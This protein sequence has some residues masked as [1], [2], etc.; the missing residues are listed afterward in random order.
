MKRQLAIIAG[1]D[2]GRCF[3]LEDGQTLFIGRGEASDT[4]IDD[5]RMSRVHCRVEVDGGSTII[6]DAE[7][8]GGTFVH[9]QRVTRKELLPG[10]V[11]RI[12]DTQLRYDLEGDRE[13]TTLLGSRSPIAT[14]EES[15]NVT[16]LQDLVGES[17]A[18]YQL[19][20][21]LHKGNTG[22]VFLAQDTKKARTAAVKVL[23]P[24]FT[25]NEEEK[26]RFVRAVQTMVNIH[27]N[28]LVELYHAGKKG[29]F[30][31]AA[32]EYI[33]GPSIL[34]VIDLIGIQ[35]M[36]DWREAFRVAVHVSRALNCAYEN[37]IIHR[38]VTPQNL[39]QRK[40]DK[41]VK[42]CDLMLA[43]AL[44]GTMAKQVTQPGQ[45][46]GDVAYMSPERTREGA[47]VDHRSDIYG[48]GAT[49]YALL[50]GHPPFESDS[51]PELVRMVRETEPVKPKEKQLSIDERFQNVVMRMLAKNPDDRYQNP[52]TLLRELEQTG[53]YAGL[54]GDYDYWT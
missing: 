41:V 28:N 13:A 2:K 53:K 14:P 26:D 12:G 7:S 34:E 20:K 5:A 9:D 15:I 48:L 11:I 10:S 52:A 45:L 42:L 25:K 35:G 50:V 33:D 30:C 49:L 31:W 36:L 32:M 46:V 21:I 40:N 27:H 4:K 38:N 43:K 37:K 17:F 1:P 47:A 8:A 51:L 23:S 39:L 22:M 24:E 3:P 16:Q 19:E 54:D 18:H 29:K 6:T 44:E